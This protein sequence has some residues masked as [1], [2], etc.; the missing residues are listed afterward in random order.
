MSAGRSPYDTAPPVA[1][2]ILRVGLALVIAFGALAV[3]IARWQVWEAEALTMAPDDPLVLAAQRSAPR[4]PIVDTRG[5]VLAETELVGGEA[6][7]QYRSVAA[8]PILGYWSPVFGTSGLERAYD[9]ELIG[10]AGGS[11][12]EALLRKF[13]RSPYDPATLHLSIDLRLQ[14]KAA[15][16]L[17]AD[18]GAIVAIEPATG[19]I[20]ALV[21]SPGYDASRIADPAE[22]PAYFATLREDPASPLLDRATQGL[23]V[24]G[25]VLKVATALAALDSGAVA[26]ETIFRDQPAEER[27]G[28][29]VEGFR[30]R[31]GH[32]PMTGDRALDLRRAIEVSCNIY[33]ARTAV[34]LGGERF[35]AWGTAAG[36]DAPIPFEL[37]TAASQLTDRPPGPNGGFRDD[38]ELANAGYGQA[39][40]LVTPLQ[41][42]LLAA[43]VANDGVAMR[44]HLVDA[45]E[46]SDGSRRATAP[47]AWRRIAA[48]TSAAVVR[49]A[50]Q[51]AVEG[52]WGR[53]FAG[54][55]KVPGVPTA[56]KSGT[57]ELGGSGEPHSW[58]IGF[59]PV[60]GARIAVAVVVEHGGRGAE[61]AVP[62]A[63]QL[64][65]F[66]L[67]LGR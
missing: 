3:G 38:A 46:W 64:M 23:Y 35:R 55:A 54:A 22:G 36:F 21:S 31:D 60:E 5:V 6:R 15:Q 32:H 12:S 59:A 47:E 42:A 13:E 33:F 58:F 28:H 52:R 61:R 43:A 25:S 1:A 48:P 9:A 20:L 50:M 37:P 8:A 7:R 17:G 44:P 16:L 10:L 41:M 18:R 39:Q 57:A 30:V 65:A 56:G 45:V 24:P 11:P 63:G 53:A 51:Q 29:V 67:G 2:A 19:R 34:L 40:V 26:P 49:E 66:Y 14:E 62:L 4:G 27:T